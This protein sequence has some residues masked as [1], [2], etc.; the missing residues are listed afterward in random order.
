MLSQYRLYRKFYN[1]T[2][3]NSGNTVH[4]L[5]DPVALSANTF[6]AGGSDSPSN[7]SIESNLGIT[8]ENAGI[9]YTDLSPYLYS[10]DNT[11]DLQWSVKYTNNVD[12]LV[13]KNLTTRFRIN[14]RSITNQL[15]IE[16]LGNN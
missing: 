11:Y 3:D 10:T 6:V 7:S 2:V 13:V 9:Y 4:T 12:D 14:Y 15:V 1:F 16:I 5:F 8:R